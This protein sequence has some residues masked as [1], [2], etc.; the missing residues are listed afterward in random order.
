MLQE[1]FSCAGGRNSNDQVLKSFTSYTWAVWAL[2]L[3][4]ADTHH[5]LFWAHIQLFQV[6]HYVVYFASREEEAGEKNNGIVGLLGAH[7]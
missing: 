5:A 1:M 2:A 6:I 3:P 4:G 7:L